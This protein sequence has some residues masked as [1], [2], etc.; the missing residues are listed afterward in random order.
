[1]NPQKEPT[2]SLPKNSSGSPYFFRDLWQKF[3]IHPTELFLRHQGI[4][5]PEELKRLAAE[6]ANR[7][8]L[9]AEKELEAARIKAEKAASA[10]EHADAVWREVEETRKSLI[11]QVEALDQQ[12]T[13]AK[14]RK[15]Q[16]EADIPNLEENIVRSFVFPFG[17]EPNACMTFTQRLLATKELLGLFP[18]IIDGIESMIAENKSQLAKIK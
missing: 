14:N 4:E 9:D 7:F 5:S 12:L 10:A 15:A 8:K 17:Y 13:D 11:H 2:P 1:M 6:E 18:R 16:L 3:C